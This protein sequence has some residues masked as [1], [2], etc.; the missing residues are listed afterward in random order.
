MATARKRW[1]TYAESARME[2]IALACDVQTTAEKAKKA[3]A[4][5]HRDLVLYYLAELHRF[6]VEIQMLLAMA[7][8]ES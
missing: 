4:G 1:P 8:G 6:G 3:I 5:G 2:S 7:K